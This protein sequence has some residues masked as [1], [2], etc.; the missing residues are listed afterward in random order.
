MSEETTLMHEI[1]IALANNRER[2]DE[3]LDE[4]ICEVRE[5][6]G[7]LLAAKQRM[8]VLSALKEIDE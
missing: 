7:R 5:L 4:A 6:G 8:A 2:L 1:L 3:E